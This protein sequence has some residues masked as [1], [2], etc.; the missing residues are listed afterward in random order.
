MQNV[1]I[2]AASI[3]E[4]K[5]PTSQTVRYPI[6]RVYGLYYIHV[7]NAYAVYEHSRTVFYIF[8]PQFWM[9]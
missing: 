5:E 9:I 3:A 6:D 1:L 7:Q 8:L 2:P 4:L